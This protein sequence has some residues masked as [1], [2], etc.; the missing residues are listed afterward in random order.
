MGRTGA[1]RQNPSAFACS[2][3]GFSLKAAATIG[4]D[5][6][7]HILAPVGSESAL[8]QVEIRASVVR[9]GKS[10]SQ[11]SQFGL[12]WRIGPIFVSCSR[13]RSKHY[14]HNRRDLKNVI[15]THRSG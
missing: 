6:M 13:R 4:I 14:A 10:L 1:C 8:I 9:G 11:H 5:I 12:N 15:G 2:A 7:K 3:E